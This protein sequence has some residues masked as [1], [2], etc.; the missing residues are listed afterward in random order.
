M[1]PHHTE[2]TGATGA[3]ER[4]GTGLW[5]AWAGLWVILVLVYLPM[6]YDWLLVEPVAKTHLLFS[7]VTRQFVWMEKVTA[8]PPE[9]RGKDEDHHADI[10]YRDEAGTYY[11]RTEFEKLLPFIYYKNM[12]MWGLLPLTLHGETFDT[13]TIKSRRRVMELTPRDILSRSVGLAVPPLLESAPGV[14]RLVFPED[15]FRLTPQGME[16]INADINA[17]DEA[18]SQA[19]TTALEEAGFEFP[20]RFAAGWPNLLKAFDAGYF[21]VDARGAVFHLRR[22]AG[23]PVVVRT[24]ISPALQTWHIAVMESAQREYLGLLLGRGENG[25]ATLHVLREDYGLIE[26]PVPG[27]DPEGMEFKLVLDPLHATAIYSDE[28]TIHGVAMDREFR[29]LRRYS[30]VMSRAKAGAVQRLGE[31]LF[32]VRL[33]WRVNPAPHVALRLGSVWSWVVVFAGVALLVRRHA[34]GQ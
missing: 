31:V 11:S 29:V 6:A 26:L 34:R 5:M 28:T 2:S 10:V 13:E 9:A 4:T 24:P 32:P 23:Q 15:R 7:P 16:F 30:H 17:V 1:M 8:P 20:A 21:L 25:A 27:Y 18:L 3:T 33:E 14:A 22:V 12:E 19:F